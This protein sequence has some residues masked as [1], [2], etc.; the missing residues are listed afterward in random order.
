MNIL[1]FFKVF[2]TISRKLNVSDAVTKREMDD[3]LRS[4][5]QGNIVLRD[6]KVIYDMV[7]WMKDDINRIINYAK[8]NNFK[9]QAVGGEVK[10]FYR[11]WSDSKEW[12]DA[13]QLISKDL[14]LHRG[15]KF[16]IPDYKKVDTSWTRSQITSKQTL[17][18]DGGT[19]SGMGRLSL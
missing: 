16:K 9:I 2:S 7:G 1:L 3:V 18:D 19:S 11:H 14:S 10:L 15:I 5:F 6:V 4:A 8:P 17:G 12:T 13:G